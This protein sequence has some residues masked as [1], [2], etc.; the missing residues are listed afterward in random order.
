MKTFEH[1]NVI[2]GI[3]AY[4]HDSA[5]VLLVNGNIV[6]A[7]Q[8]ERFSR[9]KNDESFPRNAV[10][11]MLSEY[12]L[13][14]SEL[15]AVVFYDKPILKFERL[16]ETYHRYAPQGVVSFTKSM[17]IW[18]KEK[19]F[20]RRNIIKELEDIE[21][22]KL[23][24][25]PK[26][27]FPEHHLSHA[28][29]AF[30]PSPFEEAAILTVDGVGEWA[31]TTIGRGTG[32]DIEILK[33][34]HFPH[35][36]GLLYSAFTY[37]C[38][39]KINDGEYKLMGLAPFGRRGSE[40]VAVYKRLIFRELV[41][42]KDDGSFFLNMSYFTF[43]T[44]L[45]TVNDKKWEAIFGMAARKPES[46]LTQ[47]YMDLALASQ[48]VTEEIMLRLVQSAK[49]LTGSKNLV[50]AGGVA[51]NC[52]SNEKIRASGIF[53]NVWVQP[54]AGDA[55]GALGAAL[56]AHYLCFGGERT[57]ESDFFDSMQGSYLGPAYLDSDVLKVMQKFGASF[58]QFD[59][60]EA[61]YQHTAR[62]LAQGNIVGWMQGKA[63]WGPRALGN[64]SILADARSPHMQ[65]KL[66][67]KIKYR[68]G[69]RPFAPAVLEED[70]AHYFDVRT[71]SPY[72]L[73]TAPV[74]KE[75][76]LPGRQEGTLFERLNAARSD[77][78]A[79]TH[80]DY[81]ARLQTVSRK[82]NERFWELLRA[83]KKETECSVLVNTSFNVRDEPIVLTPEDAYRCF[84]KTE[85]DALVIGNVLLLK[86][87]QL[88][89]DGA[90]LEGDG[91]VP[92]ALLACLKAPEELGGGPVSRTKG[93]FV[94]AKGKRSSDLD[95]VPSLL[96]GM[97]SEKADPVTGK[98]KAFYEENPFPN[99][100]GVQNFGDLVVRG[101]KNP[102][103]KGLLDSIGFN[104]LILE[105]GCGTGQMSHF[106]SLNNNH[107]LG[108]DLSLSSLK[109][110]IDHKR[111][112]DV[113]RVGFVQMNI[114]DLGIQ[115]N[116]FD[117]VVSTGVLH[118]TRDAR[119][120]FASIVRKAKPG[121]LIVVGLYNSYA[122]IPTW[123]RSKLIGLLGSKIDYV[124]RNRI[125]DARKADIWVKD[126]YYNPHE[127]W[128]S[129]GEVLDW[130]KENNVSYLNAYPAIIGTGGSKSG[131]DLFAPTS[132][133]SA[134]ARTATQISWLGSIASEGALFVVTGRR[135]Q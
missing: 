58:T 81:S 100:D 82:T 31:T 105:C 111:K 80:L 92:S 93:A 32:K 94:T 16:L 129:L 117:V 6:A 2:L 15:S 44:T 118:H 103:A 101:E 96:A 51:L 48:E 97:E 27:I 110:A 18:I 39:F 98:I 79:V 33:E 102:F 64:R 73:F 126:Q 89:L 71:S 13:V 68:E 83:Y 130:F 86:K 132:P 91:I 114:F 28:A 24:R 57:I 4:Y 56:I 127:T 67:L 107:V 55:G 53:E 38:G 70:A 46:E 11:W 40:R 75:R 12:A 29:S 135:E 34:M 104:K 113:A 19:L 134:L 72:M 20:T 52:V 122:R 36:L 74:K 41:D 124:V 60:T 35:S 54:A 128:H 133:G 14:P 120:A 1:R 85:M 112:N 3:S 115:D 76:R 88:T 62:L 84:M 131:E 78:P 17:P 37:Y 43:A 99:Y 42:L 30:Y 63:E 65:K 59:N 123:I 50:M 25:K 69:F 116:T 90:V 95:T 121:G 8:E 23:L 9:K 45:R 77:I 22:K 66:N 109:L 61:A 10:R 26:L 119:A 87:D 125:H 47:E 7:A 108:I 106:L 21:G 5:A 49:K